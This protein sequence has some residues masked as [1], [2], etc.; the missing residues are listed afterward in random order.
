MVQSTRIKPFSLNTIDAICKSARF[1]QLQQ[2]VLRYLWGLGC[3]SLPS[4]IIPIRFEHFRRGRRR[5]SGKLS[6]TRNSERL[7]SELQSSVCTLFFPSHS[8]CFYPTTNLRARERCFYSNA[9][10]SSEP[11]KQYF[12]RK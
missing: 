4:G 11:Y 12:M 1:R 6:S 5:A 9:R 7:S 3:T 2:W 8:F 10:R